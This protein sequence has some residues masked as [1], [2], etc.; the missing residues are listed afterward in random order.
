MAEIQF[1]DATII[2]GLD[3]LPVRS[4]GASVNQFTLPLQRL[5]SV[6]L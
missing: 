2:V 5:P 1:D 3:A 6:A 4:I